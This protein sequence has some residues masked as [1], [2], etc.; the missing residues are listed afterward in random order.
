MFIHNY[1][2]NKEMFLTFHSIH[3]HMNDF[4]YTDLDCERLWPWPEM[5]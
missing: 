5:M 3:V 1:K 2:I 4:L